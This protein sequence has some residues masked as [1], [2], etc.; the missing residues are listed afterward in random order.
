MTGGWLLGNIDRPSHDRLAVTSTCVPNA[1][2]GGPRVTIGYLDPGS[3]SLIASAVVGG[4]AAAGVA[5]RQARHRLT[6][7]IS[8]K[9]GEAE[10][11]SSD[12]ELEVDPTTTDA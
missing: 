1:T 12:A 5:F 6:S 11:T 7:K 9:R 3:G 8:R 2:Q 4:A 10:A